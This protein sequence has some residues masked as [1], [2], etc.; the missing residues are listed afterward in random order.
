MQCAAVTVFC[1]GLGLLRAQGTL[2]FSGI[3]GEVG[4]EAARGAI[5]SIENSLQ[6]FL[7]EKL[8]DCTSGGNI[9]SGIGD[10][11]GT[12]GLSRQD[13]AAELSSGRYQNEMETL[14]AYVGQRPQ[15][16][17]SD[18]ASGL[19]G[20]AGSYLQNRYAPQPVPTTSMLGSFFGSFLGSY[21]GGGRQSQG[22]LLSSLGGLASRIFSPQGQPAPQN[23]GTS[24]PYN[25]QTNPYSQAPLYPP[26][27]PS[28][29]PSS[30]PY[31]GMPAPYE[32]GPS[33]Y[34]NHNAAYNY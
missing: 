19:L 1:V 6:R 17:G 31:P 25:P 18:W 11:L 21:A 14:A 2:S 34:T 23:H 16:S 12:Q 7:C 4:A 27:A 20:L 24:P 28:Y 10:L 26:P 5:G 22:G 8:G 13:L 33:S 32:T 15:Q 29:A 9:Q 3:A 30:Y